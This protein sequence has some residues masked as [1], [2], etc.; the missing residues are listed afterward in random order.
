[1]FQCFVAKT[2]RKAICVHPEASGTAHA[3]PDN[4]ATCVCQEL[5]HCDEHV[6]LLLTA[7]LDHCQDVR[8]RVTLDV[9][10]H[11]ASYVLLLRVMAHTT[12]GNLFTSSHAVACQIVVG[13]L[14][15]RLESFVLMI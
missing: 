11:C 10:P 7:V 15:H 2:S 14:R 1:M 12:F 6:P 5:E 4:C 3:W 13:G 8:C 9:S